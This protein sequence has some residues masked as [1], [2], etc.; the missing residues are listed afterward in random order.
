MGCD[1]KT[2]RA[3]VLLL[4]GARSQRY[5]RSALDALAQVIPRAHR[6]EFPGVGHLAADNDGKP[7]LVASELRRFFRE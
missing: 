6:V 5:L 3:E 2:M 1:F 4:G 7:E